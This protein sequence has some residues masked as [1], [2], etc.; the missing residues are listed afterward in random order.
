MVALWS[1]FLGIIRNDTKLL[2]YVEITDVNDEHSNSCVPSYVDQYIIS[3][4]RSS[5]YKYCG[6]EVLRNIMIQ[7]AIDPFDDFRAMTE[8]LQKVFPERKD[9]DRDMI[10]NIRIRV[11][12]II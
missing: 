6:D 12:R 9:V 7:M 3:R 2:D 5:E 4:S 11:R 10:N 8:L 1:R